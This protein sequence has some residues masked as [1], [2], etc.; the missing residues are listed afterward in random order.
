MQRGRGEDE[1]TNLVCPYCKKQHIG[2]FLYSS[3][4]CFAYGEFGHINKNCP[5]LNKGNAP[6]PSKLNATNVG[7]AAKKN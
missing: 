2:E 1:K 6:V 3:N 7:N 4:K 5:K